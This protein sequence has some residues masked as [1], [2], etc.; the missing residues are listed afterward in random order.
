MEGRS[1]ELEWKPERCL[2]CGFSDFRWIEK[3]RDWA[4]N[5]CGAAQPKPKTPEEIQARQQSEAHSQL[6][7]AIASWG[8]AHNR[9]WN[10]TEL[11]AVTEAVE[12]F[13]S[14]WE[15]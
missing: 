10:L 8:L 15:V 2:S 7:S 14:H 12:K 4:C 13:L 3:H 9:G 1:M 6:A 11:N 5:V